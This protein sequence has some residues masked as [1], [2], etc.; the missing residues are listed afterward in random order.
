MKEVATLVCKN[1]VTNSFLCLFVLLW[2]LKTR[3]KFLGNWWS[4]NEK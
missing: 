1:V 4:G 3:S 2:K